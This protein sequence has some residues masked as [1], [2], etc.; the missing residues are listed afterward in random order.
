MTVPKHHFHS[1][2]NLSPSN[3]SPSNLSP[4]NLSPINHGLRPI[5]LSG[6]L[7]IASVSNPNR[8]I[9]GWREWVALPMLGIQRLD[10][11][12]DTGARSSSLDVH[13]IEEFRKH[14]QL[15]VR[16][17]IMDDIDLSM[18]GRVVEA[19]LVEYRNVRASSG[20]VM[21]RPVILTELSIGHHTWE[22]ELTLSNRQSMGYRM[23]VGRLAIEARFLVDASQSHLSGSRLN[24][25]T[26]QP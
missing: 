19:K 8:S 21:R 22:V 13:S 5:G 20:H 10:A 11:K 6:D 3:L 12:I 25:T 14:K 2:S 23:L 16:F 1:P 18:A 24:C 17:R 9:I 4:S 7:E 26:T 15:W